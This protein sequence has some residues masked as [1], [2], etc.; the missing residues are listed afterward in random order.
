VNF[1]DLLESGPYTLAIEGLLKVVKIESPMVKTEQIYQS[2]TKE[3]QRELSMFWNDI[4][5]DSR[6]LEIDTDTL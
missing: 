2:C 5:I 4:N 1:F 6:D 3:V